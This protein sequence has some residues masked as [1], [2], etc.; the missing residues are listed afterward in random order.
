MNLYI[1]AEET[2]DLLTETLK[3]LIRQTIEKTLEIEA[4][5]EEVEISLTCVTPESIRALNALHRQ[6]DAVT[7]VLSFPQYDEEGFMVDED[8]TVLLGD[9]VICLEQA[10]VQAKSFGHPYEREV[11]Y[12][13][14]HS[15][16]HLLGYDHETEEDKADMRVQEKKIMSAMGMSNIVEA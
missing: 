12:L 14:C 10:M 4:F 15:L 8:N 3:D 2:P 7:D 9:V 16:L 11:S 5:D 6:K 13:V 1:D